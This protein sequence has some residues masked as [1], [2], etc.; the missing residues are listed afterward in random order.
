MASSSRLSRLPIWLSRW[1]G[2]RRSTAPKQPENIVY[3]WSLVG[4]FC[5][6]A[7]LQAVFEQAH[8]F[9]NRHVPTIVASYV[10]LP[11]ESFPLCLYHF[12]NDG[13][14]GSVRRTLLRDH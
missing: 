7:I 6:L 1:L 2:Y 5:G 10:G 4:S 14:L 11:I 13:S 8:Y 12:T 9:I 3:I